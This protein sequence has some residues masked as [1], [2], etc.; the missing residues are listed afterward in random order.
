[1]KVDSPTLHVMHILE[2]TAGGSR[3]H[4]LHIV[5]GLRAA[6]VQVDL[7]LS[8]TGA[9]PDFDQDLQFYREMGCG[10]SLVD[11]TKGLSGSDLAAL[12]AVRRVLLS[13][14]PQII[15]THC[16]KAGLLGRLAA[17]SLPAAQVVHTPH[18]FFFEGFK[19]VLLRWASVMLER[20][21]G[22]R[23]RLLFCIS[24]AEEQLARELEIV[25]AECIAVGP[26]GLPEGFYEQL[27]ERDLVRQRYNIPD[28]VLAVGVFARLVKKKGHFWLLEAIR[29]IAPENLG[30]MR[31]YI[32]GY[33]PLAEQLKER[34][35]ELGLADAVVL[36]G[37]EPKAERYLRGMD[38]GVLP[39]FYEGLPYQLLETLGAGVPMIASDIPG[40]KL[41]LEGNPV[42]YV[43]PNDA[44]QL[45]ALIAGLQHNEDERR[46]IGALGEDWVRRN[47]SFAAQL[48][49]LLGAYE[50]ILRH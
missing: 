47:F 35:T 12:G 48:A 3:K 16:A 8:K 28:D 37:Y 18:S 46:R 13:R 1:M 44:D 9:D 34:V 20:W 17:R 4:L 30:K 25:P 27:E 36:A 40:N 45:A 41:N 2:A 15:H 23:T 19:S 26:N 33:G 11:M 21:L 10:L 24:A 43:Q 32:F 49:A 7:I 50:D 14:R 42:L 29:R 6:E 38:L 31:F 5:Q 39:S 22:K